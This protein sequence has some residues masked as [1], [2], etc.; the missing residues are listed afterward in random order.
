M[1]LLHRNKAA[2]RWPT[3]DKNWWHPGPAGTIIR[4]EFFE[5]PT[6]PPGGS[7]LIKVW[8]GTA[9]VEKPVK[10]WTGSAWVTKPLKRWNGTAWV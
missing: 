8:N 6:P 3:T 4:N 9:W 10:V 5:A 1:T 2:P 7:G